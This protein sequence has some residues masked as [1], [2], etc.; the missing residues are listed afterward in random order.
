[1]QV[2]AVK[3][4]API[5]H[6]C[7]CAD[8]YFDGKSRLRGTRSLVVVVVC[9][10]ADGK[11]QRLLVCTHFRILLERYNV[12]THSQYHDFKQ[13]VTKCHSQYNFGLFSSILMPWGFFGLVLL[14]SILMPWDFFGFF[15][16][17]L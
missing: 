9:Q 11:R 12:P 3:G 5:I 15:I 8:S 2:L 1:M 6:S 7:E 13:L 16:F 17:G 10:T 4:Q 14:S